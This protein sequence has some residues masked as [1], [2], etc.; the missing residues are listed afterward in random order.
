[1]KKSTLFRPDQQIH[2]RG[3]Y[4]AVNIGMTADRGLI[5]PTNLKV[6]NNVSDGARL[7]SKCHEMQRLLNFCDCTLE[8]SQLLNF[9]PPSS[10]SP[11]LPSRSGPRTYMRT[12][13]KPW[14]SSPTIPSTETLRVQEKGR[15]L[16]R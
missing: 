11:Q 7:L 16:R 5:E 15:R 6:P 1:M 12:T 3:N 8:A 10:L 2:Q 13:G 14:I 9:G 4:P